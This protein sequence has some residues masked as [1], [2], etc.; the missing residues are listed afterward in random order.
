MKIIFIRGLPGTGKTII[1]KI[2]KEIFLNSE[3]VSVD[4][5]KIQA[6]KKN[7]TFAEAN[8]L[9]F[10]KAIKKLY[11]L[12]KTKEI[13]IFEEMICNRE[14]YG[15]LRN[16]IR[17]IG[18]KVYWFRITRKLNQLLVEESKRKRGIKNTEKD[19]SDLKKEIETIRIKGEHKIKNDDLGKTI[20]KI[21]DIVI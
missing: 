12:S 4:K 20:K 19:F 3:V 16:F 11:D 15:E 7:F 8:K 2:L 9:A 21:L 10:E 13:I 14:L 6:L 18:C 1:A 5:L 17:N